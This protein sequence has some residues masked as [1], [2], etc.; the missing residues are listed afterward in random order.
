MTGREKPPVN[1][2]ILPNEGG[3]RDPF[4]IAFNYGASNISGATGGD[5]LVHS[6]DWSECVC[7][8]GW[9][10]DEYIGCQMC[11]PGHFC[12]EGIR[13]PCRPHHFQTN[14]EA[15][16][17]VP[18]V[19][20]GDQTGKFSQCD[21]GMQLQWCLPENPL[22]QNRPLSRNCIPCQQC[23]RSFITTIEGQVGCYRS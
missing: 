7:K 18:C 20:T 21:T 6:Q 2:K 17:C 5:K 19:D 8:P 23:K 16:A 22:T 3:P 4:L 13:S 11:E 9:Y 1:C 15:S 14:W 12:V 10:G